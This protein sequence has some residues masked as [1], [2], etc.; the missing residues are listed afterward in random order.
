MEVHNRHELDRALGLQ[1][2][3]VGIN[4]RNLKTLKTDL[5]IV[6]ELGPHVPPDRFVI[7]ESGLRTHDDPRRMADIGVSAFLVGES[8]MRQD[9]V[10]AATRRLLNG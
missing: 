9:D 2:K 7:A 4:A 1:T 5:T 6:E 8:L 3:L 10:E